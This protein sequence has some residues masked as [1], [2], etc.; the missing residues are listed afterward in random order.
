[1]TDPTNP[2]EMPTPTIDFAMTEVNG[3]ITLHAANCPEART[4]AMMGFPVAT[5]IEAKGLPDDYPRHSCLE[6]A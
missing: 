4:M 1:M 6:E 3:R 2:T 5:F